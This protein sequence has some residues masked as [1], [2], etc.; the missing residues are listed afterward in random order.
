M[1]TYVCLDC[2]VDFEPEQYGL[3]V[4]HNC[5]V[6]GGSSSFEVRGVLRHLPHTL[7]YVGTPTPPQVPDSI[8]LHDDEPTR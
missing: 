5:A 2:H 7:G 6:T 4:G 3:H 8:P 1:A